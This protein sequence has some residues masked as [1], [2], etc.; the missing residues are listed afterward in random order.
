MKSESKIEEI[1][2]ALW[3]IAWTVLY[4]HHAPLW[5][6]WLVGLKFAANYLRHCLRGPRDP[7]RAK[8][9]ISHLPN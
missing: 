2:A 1:L 3:F 4:T 7:R 5:L 9:V 6:L 8:E